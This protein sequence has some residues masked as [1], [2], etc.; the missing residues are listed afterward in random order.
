MQTRTLG[1]NGPQVSALGLG[2]MGMSEFY[3]TGNEAES[4]ATLDKAL[5][6]GCNF[7]DTSDMYGPATNE[8]L[9]AKALKGRRQKVFLATKFGIV[10]GA[11]PG[12]RGLNGKPE[13]VAQ[14]CEAS[15]K[16]LG[17]EHIDLYY[18]HRLDPETPIEHTVAAMAQLVKQGKVRHL[19]LSEVGPQTLRRA[20]RVHPITALQTEYSLWTRDPESGPLQ[21][22]RELGVGLVAYSPLGRGMLTGRFKSAEDFAPDDYRRNSP[23]FQG[24]NFAKNLGLVRQVEAMAKAKGVLP[25]QLALAWV[26]A[27]GPDVVPIPG[28]KQ[29]KYL[30]QNLGSLSVEL[31]SAD[32]AQLEAAFPLGAAQGERYPSAV[33]ASINRT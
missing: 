5:E 6:L 23:R 33:M 32:L 13:Y 25:S 10:R 18:L 27:Q 15:L 19:G 2:C 14:A 30:E 24:G 16:R 29:R 20:Q 8:L 31:S 9:L 21:A 11:D 3:G 7:W 4:L 1:T 26:L 17:V 22:C 12:V 28:T